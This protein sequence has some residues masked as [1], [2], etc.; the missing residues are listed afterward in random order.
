MDDDDAFDQPASSLSLLQQHAAVVVSRPSLVYLAAFRRLLCAYENM[1]QTDVWSIYRQ[2]I[3][4]V[5]TQL[6]VST[7]CNRNT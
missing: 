1:L 2:H 6:S 3:R 7:V 4:T 5:F